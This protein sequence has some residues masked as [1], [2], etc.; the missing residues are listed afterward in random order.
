MNLTLQIVQLLHGI[1][2]VAA[3]MGISL[4]R[5]KQLHDASGGKITDADLQTLAK[6]AQDAID[7]M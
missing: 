1:V 4:D 6:E 7:D 3:S 2:S 5:Y